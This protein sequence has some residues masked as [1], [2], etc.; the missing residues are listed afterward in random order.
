MEYTRTTVNMTA[1]TTTMTHKGMLLLGLI[2]LRLRFGYD[3]LEFFGFFF[4][5]W[6]GWFGSGW[7][8]RFYVGWFVW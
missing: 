1:M 3:R 8:D 4:V 2:W 5:W 7:F 6:R